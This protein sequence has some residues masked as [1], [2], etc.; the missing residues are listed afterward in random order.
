MSW[1]WERQKQPTI[2]SHRLTQ[3][4]Q[5]AGGLEE[6]GTTR[7]NIICGYLQEQQGPLRRWQR[8]WYVLKD[9]MALYSY[10]APEDPVACSTLP[11]PGYSAEAYT[12]VDWWICADE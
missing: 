1:R 5:A 7:K 9:D 2:S 8:R 4:P 12:K 11:L 10:K 6:D 3:F